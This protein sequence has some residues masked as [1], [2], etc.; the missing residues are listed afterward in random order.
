MPGR[1]PRKSL[2]V[3]PHG[4]AIDDSRPLALVR[5]LERWQNDKL[6]H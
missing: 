4:I 2:D 3:L 5:I 1:F 6:I